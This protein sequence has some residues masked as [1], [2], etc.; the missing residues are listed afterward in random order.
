LAAAEALLKQAKI[1]NEG[2]TE[3]PHVITNDSHEN[4]AGLLFALRTRPQLKGLGKLT[5]AQRNKL[6]ENEQKSIAK[7]EK[8][9]LIVVLDPSPTRRQLA[10]PPAQGQ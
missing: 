2:L 6:S 7:Q 5:E 4:I 10:T 3:T 1:W 8:V 9:A